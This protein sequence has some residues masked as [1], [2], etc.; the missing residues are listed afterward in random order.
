MTLQIRVA[1]IV[2]SAFF[3]L[4]LPS[5]SAIVCSSECLFG[6]TALGRDGVGLADGP[7]WRRPGRRHAI[8]PAFPELLSAQKQIA[9]CLSKKWL[10]VYMLWNYGVDDYRCPCFVHGYRCACLIF[11]FRS[12]TA[13]RDAA[14]STSINQGIGP[15]PRRSPTNQNVGPAERPSLR[16]TH[17]GVGLADAVKSRHTAAHFS[18]RLSL[19]LDL[20]ARPIDVS[21]RWRANLDFMH[22]VELV[23]RRC[24][25]FRRSLQLRF[26]LQEKGMRGFRGPTFHLQA[27]QVGTI[28]FFLALFGHILHRADG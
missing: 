12:R 24:D 17:Q 5:S 26:E 8:S 28:H 1:Q 15:S 18:V 23:Q 4:P 9:S 27:V 21:F 6:S 11:Y 2:H 13:P 3:F 19:D 14:T 22:R 16:S 20:L 7:R 10:Q 25:N